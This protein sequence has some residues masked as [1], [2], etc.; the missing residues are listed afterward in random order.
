MKRRGTKVVMLDLTR[1]EESRKAYGAE[2]MNSTTQQIR[3]L[4]EEYELE[5]LEYPSVLT[6]DH[7]RDFAHMNEKGRKVF[8]RW[9]LS[10]LP[11]FLKRKQLS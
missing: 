1:S 7:Y 10:E 9:F 5:F 2:F 4:R 11:K 6:L 3:R 8:S